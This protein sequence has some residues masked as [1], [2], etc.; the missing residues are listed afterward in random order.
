MTW[1]NWGRTFSADPVSVETPGSVDELRELVTAH[2]GTGIGLKSVGAGHSFSAAAQPD[3]AQL[4][5]DRFAG[6]LRVDIESGRVRFGAGTRLFRVAP[7][8]APFGL[9]LPNMGDI[10]R[11]T[12]AGAISTGTHG[13][14]LAHPSIGANV[15]AVQMV[16]GRGE[17]LEISAESNPALLPAV[18]LG[19]GALGVITEVEIQCVP[20]FRLQAREASEPLEQVLGEWDARI[21]SADHFEFYWFPHTTSA[22]TKTNTRTDAPAE[23]VHPLRRWGDAWLLQGAAFGAMNEAATAF[24]AAVP[25]LNGIAAPLM[26]G[27][28]HVD[29]SDRVF[30]SRR[31]LRFREMEF[32]VPV[33]AMQ[34]ALRD[35]AGVVERSREQV[36]FPVEVRAAAADDAMLSTAHGR[37]VAYIA[38]HSYVRQDPRRLFAEAQRALL[39]HEGRPHWGK[40]HSVTHERFRGMLP[41]FERFLAMRDELDPDRVFANEYTRRVLGE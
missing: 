25:T 41:Q 9:A 31:P 8:L 23:P 39:A 13:T 3:G 14:G 28:G 5:L 7:L 15:T 36:A 17:V 11:Q 32:A 29:R 20:A 12:I 10:D 30:V 22:V 40:M 6:L 16:T 27:A 2:R 38:I 37:D 34:D 33:A 21:R 26:P 18:R 24:P 19:L 35:I 4:R 1:R